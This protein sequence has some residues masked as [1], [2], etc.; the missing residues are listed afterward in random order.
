MQNQGQYTIY[1]ANT[2]TNYLK[3]NKSNSLNIQNGPE[4]TLYTAGNKFY[5][6]NPNASVEL[7]TRRSSNP[8]KIESTN[9][10]YSFLNKNIEIK[11]QPNNFYYPSRGYSEN[12]NRA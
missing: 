2:N 11:N 6:A 8:S 10:N 5:S 7:N 12:S 1:Q 4:K 3:V 9:N